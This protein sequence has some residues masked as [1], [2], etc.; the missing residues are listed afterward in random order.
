MTAWLQS[1]DAALFRFLNHSLSNPLFDWL[2]PVLSGNK[3]FAP[4]VAV[5]A[6]LLVWRQR[7]KG[8]LCVVFIA[9]AVGLGDPLLINSRSEEHTSELQSN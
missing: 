5:A 8:A 2:M 6:A 9:L 7:V 1:L 3:F 4:M